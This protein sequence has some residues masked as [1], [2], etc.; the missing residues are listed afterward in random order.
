MD[1]GYWHVLLRAAGWTDAQLGRLDQLRAKAERGDL[2]WTFAFKSALFY[3]R[4]YRA[5][6]I[7]RGDNY[8]SG[9]VLRDLPRA[10]DFASAEGRQR[11]P[12]YSG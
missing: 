2:E 11:S 5:G 9:L 7:G 1:I 4:L 8:S 12:D 10:L 6:R 3:R